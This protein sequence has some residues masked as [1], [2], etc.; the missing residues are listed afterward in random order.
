MIDDTY[1]YLGIVI[2]SKLKWNENTE[3]TMKNV[4]SRMYCLMKLKMFGVSAGLLLKFYNAVISSISLL[5]ACWGLN[6]SKHDQGRVD[7]V[8]HRASR[9]VGRQTDNFQLVGHHSKPLVH[10]VIKAPDFAHV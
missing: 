7:K 10:Y 1:K 3:S 9:I 8:T 4:N 2:E 6:V 5:A